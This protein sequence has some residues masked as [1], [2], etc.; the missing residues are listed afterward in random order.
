MRKHRPF[1]DGLANASK[2]PFAV[3]PDQPGRGGEHQKAAIGATGRMRQ[4]RPLPNQF[5]NASDRH[6]AAT[7]ANAIV[8]PSHPKAMPVILPTPAKVDRCFPRR[9]T[10]PWSRNG[11][12]VL[13]DAPDGSG[14]AGIATVRQSNDE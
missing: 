10:P 1:A 6:A 13:T 2:R 7:E 5:V 12:C 3:L 4:E 8:A 14:R 11:R 9:R